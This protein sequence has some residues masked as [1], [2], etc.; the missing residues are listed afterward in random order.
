MTLTLAPDLDALPGLLDFLAGRGCHGALLL[1]TTGEGPAFSVAERIEVLRAGLRHRDG[2]LPGF[3]VLAGTGC[4]SLPDTIALTKAAFD[5]GVDGV[6]VLPAFYFKGVGADGL[7]HYFDEL[8]RAAVP[9]EGALLADGGACSEEEL[10]TRARQALQQDK[11]LRAVIQADGAVPHR[12]V[13][14]VLDLL[15]AEGLTRV[16]FGAVKPETS[17]A[18]E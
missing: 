12:R 4:A 18:G 10:R 7:V 1:G 14:E 8:V 15:R 3:Q 11:A 17:G 13:M 6:V 16:A 2:A 5:L 9:P